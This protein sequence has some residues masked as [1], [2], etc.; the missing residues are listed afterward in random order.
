MRTLSGSIAFVSAELPPSS[1]ELLAAQG[2]VIARRQCA[3]SGIAARTMR[4]AVGNGSW[5]LLQRGLYAAFPGT[6]AA[7]RCCGPPCS[8]LGPMPC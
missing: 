4:T 5:Q 7:R 1:R 6:L 2:R 3:K 8:G